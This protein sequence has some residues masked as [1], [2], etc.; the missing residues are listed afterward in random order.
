[1]PSVAGCSHGCEW[2]KRTRTGRFVTDYLIVEAPMAAVTPDSATPRLLGRGGGFIP[3]AGRPRC[4]WLALAFVAACGSP[5]TSLL[6][7]LSL[8]GVPA[9][10]ML[11]VQL[12][13]HGRLFPSQLGVGSQR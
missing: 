9:P 2:M 7:D 5:P 11:A 3:W 13:G 1:M 10:A 4:F 12:Y 6:V 8:S